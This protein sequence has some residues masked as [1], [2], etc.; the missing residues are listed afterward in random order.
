[1]L[2]FHQSR[3]DGGRVEIVEPPA[4]ETFEL[5]AIKLYL[6]VQHDVEDDL[7]REMIVAARERLEVETNRP[8]LAQTCR[9]RADAFPSWRLLLW[10]DVRE[11]RSVQYRDA[12][13]VDQELDAGA[14]RLMNRA[15]LTPRSGWPIGEDIRVTFTA[16]AFEM[17][18]AVPKSL[19]QWMQLQ[20]GTLYALRQSEGT[21]QT[22][23]IPS[24]HVDGLL[25]DFRSPLL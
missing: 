10:H 25:D 3:V 12:Q 7:I 17:P 19:C 5:A 2:S 6:K 11:V 16:G 14:W 18:A 23:A 4:A 15:W 20:I 21:Q 24:R 13:G 22:Y 9:V 8:V 1:M